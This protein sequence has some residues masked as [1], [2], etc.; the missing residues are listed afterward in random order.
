MPPSEI[1]MDFMAHYLKVRW[2]PTAVIRHV[3][4][5]GFLSHFGAQSDL[6]LY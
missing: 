4:V 2:E 3:M 6:G 5:L 1:E